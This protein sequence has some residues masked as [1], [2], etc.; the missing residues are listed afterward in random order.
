MIIS[1]W[2]LRTSSKYSC[3]K[4]KK[5]PESSEMDSSL[6]GADF[7]FVQNIA[8]PS[9]SHDRR[10]KMEHTSKDTLRSKA[11][12]NIFRPKSADFK[13]QKRQKSAAKT[14]YYRVRSEAT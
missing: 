2:W 12:P 1:T 7:G 6:A 14:E 3:K 10:I 13:Q 5:Q 11:K 8:P 4:S 9:L